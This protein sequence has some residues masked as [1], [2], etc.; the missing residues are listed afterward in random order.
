[1]VEA[2]W[3]VMSG[4]DRLAFSEAY[5]ESGNDLNVNVQ[6]ITRQLI[7][8][9][10]SA[11]M[12]GYLLKRSETLRRWNQRWFTLDPPTGHMEYRYQRGD[13]HPRGQILLVPE[14]QICIS[15]INF[16]G[17]TEYDGCCFYLRTIG[18]KELYLAAKTPGAAQAWVATLRASVVVLK[19][20]RDAVNAIG[21][22]SRPWMQGSDA[23]AA[24]AAAASATANAA[25][26]EIEAASQ[27][28]ARQILARRDL[29]PALAPRGM[30]A[31]RVHPVDPRSR[32]PVGKEKKAGPGPVVRIANGAR[33]SA[34]STDE[35][36]VETLRVKDEELHQLAGDLRS[37]E[38]II[39]EM[40]KRLTDTADAAEA[41]A[42][43]AEKMD[44]ERKAA[45]ARVQELEKEME[46][47]L[48]VTEAMLKSS[49]ER[50]QATIAEHNS[51]ISER[52]RAMEE[53]AQWRTEAARL[54]E[55]TNYLEQRLVAAES[56]RRIGTASEEENVKLAVHSHGPT[57]S[58]QEH[59]VGDGMVYCRPQSE[60]DITEDAEEK[61]AVAVGV[62]SS[63]GKYVPNPYAEFG[64]G[65]CKIPEIF[66]APGM[67]SPD[68]YRFKQVLPVQMEYVALAESACVESLF[69]LCFASLPSDPNDRIRTNDPDL[70]ASGC[71][72]TR[73]RTGTESGTVPVAGVDGLPPVSF[74]G[75]HRAEADED[76]NG[77]GVDPLG[78][79]LTGT[80][81]A[82]MSSSRYRS[83]AGDDHDDVACAEDQRIIR[84]DESKQMRSEVP[85][86]KSTLLHAADGEGWAGQPPIFPPP[87]SDVVDTTGLDCDQEG[88]SDVL[89]PTTSR[90]R[91]T[92]CGEVFRGRNDAVGDEWSMPMSLRR[93]IFPDDVGD[94]QTLWL[95]SATR[96]SQGLP[97]QLAEL[98]AGPA[99]AYWTG[100]DSLEGAIAQVEREMEGAVEGESNNDVCTGFVERDSTGSS[101]SVLTP[102]SVGASS[103][104]LWA[105]ALNGAITDAE[106]EMEG[107]TD[108][109]DP[110]GPLF[111]ERETIGSTGSS[112]SMMTALSASVCSDS[113]WPGSPY[114]TSIGPDH[115]RSIVAPP[116]M[117]MAA[118]GSS[119]G[120][121][122]CRHVGLSKE[123]GT[124][125]GTVGWLDAGQ[126]PAALLSRQMDV[127]KT[128]GG[129]DVD[130][131]VSS[132]NMPLDTM[133]R[134]NV[135][136][137]EAGLKTDERAEKVGECSDYEDALEEDSTD[138][139]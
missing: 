122:A 97:P 115:F 96:V 64:P 26:K 38:W 92:D 50:E 100:R 130:E 90:T 134:D 17:D 41:A 88:E 19:A 139:P 32:Q 109:I 114:G 132:S 106:T 22:T 85:P 120:F 129:G 75:S 31:N 61:S 56:A 3:M 51:A 93:G 107:G 28:A 133:N 13:P 66:P 29:A 117:E 89:L 135:T 94:R 99:A 79:Q 24:A 108:G 105:G 23:V 86:S 65:L 78:G 20:H 55:K 27:T 67:S 4:A 5:K 110:A 37:K 11:P 98:S 9:V 87:H 127:C 33:M 36:F 48:R 81:P 124:E 14:S 73:A 112:P 71:G 123:Q 49:Q 82:A 83:S 68:H 84:L 70:N 138:R 57:S 72:G 34:P 95:S 60:G 54:V 119:G 125:Q 62:G 111:L 102:L 128:G 126:V 40:V 91:E 77:M 53:A 101:E 63:G 12:E 43:A 10:G 69:P 118:E 30:M 8:P 76:R 46:E 39:R 6:R 47:K 59:G 74:D 137:T 18:K 15:P 25:K 7:P 45:E 42:A 136:W 121:I 104:S 116:D 103:N 58:Q 2:E 52:D 35:V 1:M 80:G 44:M 131:P 21:D 16:H 113:P